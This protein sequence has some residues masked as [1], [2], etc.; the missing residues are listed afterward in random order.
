MKSSDA[1]LLLGLAIGVAVGAA[2]GYLVGSEKGEELLEEI[3]DI[4]GKAKEGFNVAM[5]KA[6]TTGQDALNQAKKYKDEAM[7]TA[8]EVTE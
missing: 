2:V 3:K 6:K 4:A 7:K 8:H 5:E 1:K